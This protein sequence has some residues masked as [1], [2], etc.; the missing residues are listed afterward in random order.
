LV[1]D[2]ISVS[3]EEGKTPICVVERKEGDMVGLWD[4][5]REK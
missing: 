5:E 3:E 1:S 4:E 2:P